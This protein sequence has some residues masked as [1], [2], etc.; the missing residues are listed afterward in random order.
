MIKEKELYRYLAN[1]WAQTQE[2]QVSLA[3][4]RNQVTEAGMVQEEVEIMEVEIM[5]VE[6]MVETIYQELAKL[7]HKIFSQVVDLHLI[8]KI[9]I[10]DKMIYS[11]MM[12]SD[13][14]NK[15]NLEEIILNRLLLKINMQ[16][17][18]I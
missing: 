18:L 7:I 14:R 2:L 3:A 12:D 1:L 5:V 4:L 8:T 17:E 16:V 9:E 15:K 10:G 11:M 13:L 6:V